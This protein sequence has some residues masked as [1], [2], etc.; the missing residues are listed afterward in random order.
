MPLRRNREIAHN[1]SASWKHGWK[2]MSEAK[3]IEEG[4]GL[5]MT[6]PS[7]DYLE[8]TIKADLIGREIKKNVEESWLICLS[9][10]LMT[11]ANQ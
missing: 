3:E 11:E 8:P 9:W 7:W 6:V 10:K 1:S 2:T 4:G 5:E